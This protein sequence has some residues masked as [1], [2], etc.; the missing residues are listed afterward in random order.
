MDQINGVCVCVS[1]AYGGAYDVMSSKH[2]RGDVNYAWPSAEVAV[3]GAKVQT[4]VFF[5]LYF[6]LSLPLSLLFDLTVCIIRFFL[7]AP[8]RSSSEERRTRR[9]QRRNT[10]RSSPTPSQLLSEVNNV[11]LFTALSERSCLRLFKLY[12]TI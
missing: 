12:T 1:Q 3:M 9:R 4:H 5:C 7:R 6:F 2:L 8:C 11:T 10:W